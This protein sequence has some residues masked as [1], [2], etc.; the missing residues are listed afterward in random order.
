[1]ARRPFGT[2]SAGVGRGVESGSTNTPRCGGC[3]C[4]QIQLPARRAQR[5]AIGPEVPAQPLHNETTVPPRVSASR[6][7]CVGGGQSP[8]ATGTS[9]VTA[10]FG[11]GP[12]RA[13]P[14]RLCLAGL[15]T[16]GTHRAASTVCALPAPRRYRS[17]D[18]IAPDLAVATLCFL[19]PTLP[20]NGTQGA[21]PWRASPRR[22]TAAG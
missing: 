21:R 20:A 1:M 15:D 16:T 4:F 5:G 14:P 12:A 11:C 3:L 13:A 7:L 18:R 2:L 17:S 9:R 6:R 10:I 22:T 19:L 8:P